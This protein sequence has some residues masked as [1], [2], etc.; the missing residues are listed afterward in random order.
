MA[1]D[2]FLNYLGAEK[3]YSPNTFIAYKT[4]IE[5]F[6]G[7]LKFKFEIFDLTDANTQMIKDWVMHLVNSGHSSRT[8][9]RKISSIK[10]FFRY[11]KTEDK[12]KVNPAIK[13]RSLKSGKRLPS[14]V[15]KENMA[16]LLNSK[17]DENNFS[18]L[19]DRL[20]ME[21]FYRTGVRRNELIELQEKSIDFSGEFL[22]V[23]GKGNKERIIPLTM[24]LSTIIRKYLELKNK[25]FNQTEQYLFVTDKGTKVYPKYIYRLVNKQLSGFTSAKKSPHVLRHSFATHMLNNGADLNTIKELLGHANLSATQVYTHSSIEQLKK[26]YNH[27]HPRANLKKGG[28]NES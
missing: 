16:I 11:L 6:Q 7:Y 17:F 2:N 19:R 14:Y 13:I 5:A 22:K 21:L 4:D 18:Q 12:I 9:N 28:N 8:I 23:K 26:I 27:S 15:E 24:K 20:I 3:K 25:T 1:I 10:S